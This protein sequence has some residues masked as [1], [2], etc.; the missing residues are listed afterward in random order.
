[1][2][3]P[4]SRVLRT[5][6]RDDFLPSVIPE[7]RLFSSSRNARSAY[8]G[9]SLARGSLLTPPCRSVPFRVLPWPHRQGVGHNGGERGGFW[10]PARACFARLAGMTKEEEVARDD[11][12]LRHPGTCSFFPPSRNAPPFFLVIPEAR[13]AGYPGSR[14]RLPYASPQSRHPVAA[15]PGQRLRRRR[16]IPRA[17]RG[18]HG[19]H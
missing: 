17:F 3:D 16:K 7:A 18:F 9:S 12:L 10:I 1:M 14:L 5:L 19:Y 11:F 4:G 6:G 8:P 15:P 2:L 13:A